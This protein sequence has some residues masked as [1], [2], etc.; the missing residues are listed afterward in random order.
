MIRR[1]GNLIVISGPSGVGKSTLVKQFREKLPDL[2]FSIS[3]TTRQPRAGEMDGRE[4]FFLNEND[5][6]QKV[7]A[8]EFLEYAGIFKHRYGTLKS[9]VLNRITRGEEVLLDIDV[10]GAM[11]IRQAAAADPVLA[12]SVQFIMI[13]PPD[14][15]TLENRLRGRQSETEEQLSLRLAGAKKEL[16]HFRIYDYLVVN[17]DLTRAAQ[18]LT[19][20]LQSMRTRC[21]TI[22][23][24][25]FA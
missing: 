23:G 3:C 17:D 9:E 4:Y 16:S 5:F 8:G 11:Q 18:E 21:A 10:Q 19:A 20:L 14:L 25:P 15:A 12:A 22:Q 2:Q 7:A 1:N 24:E 6:E 13:V